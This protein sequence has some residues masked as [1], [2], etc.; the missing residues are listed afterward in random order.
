MKPLLRRPEV[1]ADLERYWHHLAAHNMD[2]ADRFLD[3][4]EAG[5]RAIQRT[6]AIGRLRRW[7][8][9]R[10]ADVRSWRVP[11]YRNWLVFYRETPAGIDVI[12]VL[13]GMMDLEARMIGE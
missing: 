3:A 12:R 2:A 5:L 8:D 4:V 7:K 9:S 6:P 1:D 13:H 11:G 10:L